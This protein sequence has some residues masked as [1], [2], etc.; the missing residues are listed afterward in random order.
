MYWSYRLI[1]SQMQLQSGL[2]YS[3]YSWITLVQ[4]ST[5][6][7]STPA[8]FGLSNTTTQSNA[9]RYLSSLSAQC[10]D[11]PANVSPNPPPS[12]V[13]SAEAAAR[14]SYASEALTATSWTIE[15]T[16]TAIQKRSNRKRRSWA[17]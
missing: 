5:D 17:A 11:A 6:V 10:G 9:E 4:N 8:S 16:N 3:Q 15:P 2:D 12:V 1:P 14:S 7:V 13:W